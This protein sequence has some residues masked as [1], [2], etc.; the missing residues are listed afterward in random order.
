MKKV[1]DNLGADL[2]YRIERVLPIFTELFRAARRNSDFY[3]GRQWTKEELRALER[4]GRA[5]Y[6]WNKIQT[7]IN[8]IVGMQIQTRLDYTVQAATPDQE[9]YAQV[10]QELLAWAMRVNDIDRIETEVFLHGLLQGAAIT[11]VRWELSDF[12]GGFPK[13]ER[14][15]IYQMFWDATDIDWSLSNAQWVARVIPMTERQLVA[16][17]PEKADEIK[18]WWMDTALSRLPLWGY[19]T[20][21]QEVVYYITGRKNIDN[22]YWI[23]EFYENV[24]KPIYVAMDTIFNNSVEFDSERNAKAYIEGLLSEYSNIPDIE[25]IDENGYDRCYV[26]TTYRNVIKQYILAGQNIVEETETD[27]TNYPFQIYSALNVDGSIGT[28]VDTLIYPQRFL[29]RMISEWDNILSRTGRG[30]L[31]VVE[32]LLPRDWDAAR[33]AKVRS[34]TAATIPVLRH[35]AIQQ[36]PD[37]TTTPD[38]PQLINVVQS[39]M[40]EAGGGQNILGLQENAAESGKAVRARQAAAGLGRVPL[41]YNLQNWKRDVSALCIWFIRN[42]MVEDQIARILSKSE[43]FIDFELSPEAFN[44]LRAMETDVAITMTVD[45]ETARQEVYNQ[46]LQMLSTGLG[47]ALSP[48]TLLFILVEMNPNLTKEVKERILSSEPVVQQVLSKIKEEEHMRKVQQ[49]GIDSAMRSQVRQQA[50]EQSRPTQP[51]AE[52]Q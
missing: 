20:R 31:T 30:I 25:L 18:R 46:L 49:Q 26:A 52:Q 5:P 32:S 6:V 42:Y 51:G 17:L 11:Q 40:M 13:V 50:M 36:I 34:Q 39:F 15:P 38:I 2:L 35:D 41:F 8:N 43:K 23:V 3:L 33:I 21:N 16:Y 1:E 47:S 28:P 27:L 14:V 10:M 7:Y 12:W 45:T 22:V 29:N 24:R 37:H 48:Q 44:S 19:L 9:P 4:Q